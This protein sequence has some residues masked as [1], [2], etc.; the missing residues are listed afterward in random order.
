MNDN[1]QDN[2]TLQNNNLEFNTDG[3]AKFGVI[4]VVRDVWNIIKTPHIKLDIYK[5]L[6]VSWVLVLIYGGFSFSQA[7][8]RSKLYSDESL[9]ILL[10]GTIFFTYMKAKMICINLA[11]IKVK[12]ENDLVNFNSCLKKI[13]LDNITISY[14]AAC[15]YLF[16]GFL[17]LFFEWIIDYRYLNSFDRICYNL[18]NVLILFWGLVLDLP[19]IYLAEEKSEKI[20]ISYSKCLKTIKNNILFYIKL[21]LFLTF[22]FLLLLLAAGVLFTFVAFVLSKTVF[23]GYPLMIFGIY[24]LLKAIYWIFPFILSIMPCVY[25]REKF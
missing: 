8:G 23:I 11:I 6:L 10:Y 18:L 9:S 12:R 24:L 13:K 2:V 22:L 7:S 16:I 3:P 1:I 17:L 21:F 20:Y 19:L 25:I 5:Y 14:C 4:D 15:N